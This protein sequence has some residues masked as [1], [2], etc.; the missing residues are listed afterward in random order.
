MQVFTS[1]DVGR[2]KRESV[3][4]VGGS[5]LLSG[6]KFIDYDYIGVYLF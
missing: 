1:L 4:E 3:P 2:V 6:N 5:Y